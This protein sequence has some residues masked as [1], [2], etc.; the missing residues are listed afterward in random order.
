MRIRAVLFVLS[1]LL[2]ITGLTQLLP[3]LVAIFLDER[4]SHGFNDILGFGSSIAFSLIIGVA[5]RRFLKSHASNV[6]LREGFGVVTT[7]W[8]VL[9]L[10]G[11]LPYL[12]CGATT[13]ITDAFFETMSGFTTTGATVFPKVEIFSPALHVWRAMTQWLGGMGIVV[14]SVA[15]LP[16]LGIGGYRLLKAETP[17]GFAFERDRPRITDSAKSLW[18]LYLGLTG[19]LAII[20]WG[21][22]MSVI[23]AVS[24][25]FTTLSSGGFSTHSESIGFFN[26]PSIEWVTIVFMVIAG[27][28]FTLIPL[29]IDRPKKV[30]ENLEYKTYLGII[31]FATGL[32]FWLVPQSTASL[33]HLRTSTFQVVSIITSTGYATADYETWPTLIRMMLVYFMITGAC[34][35]STSGG[36]KL[37]RIL[38]FFKSVT[39]E[40][41]QMVYPHAVKT[42][43]L[44]RK[45]IRD[46]VAGNMM[47][48]GS[49]FIL[50][51]T[52]G[53][54]AM[55]LSGYNLEVSIGTAISALGNTGPALGEL[56]PTGNWAGLPDTTKWVMA[57]LMLCGRLELFSV[58]VLFSAW[59]WRR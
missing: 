43:K 21:L 8:I 46:D 25:A 38:V 36:V 33:D 34:M 51:M 45:M 15:L 55:V 48:F 35:G 3:L 50:L 20:Y 53:V 57:F 44:G 52:V 32:T 6:G 49:L 47:A 23:D 30:I 5:G 17:G 9:S 2:A 13:S 56:G 29:F 37:T 19:V 10:F 42:I 1:N 41:H 58:I 4:E 18:R 39:R 40:L 22:G 14:L 27:T 59:A 31:L 54:I 26:S 11:M 7:A 28:N 16:M 24:H 12:F